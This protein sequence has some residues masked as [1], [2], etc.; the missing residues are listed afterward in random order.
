M[1][2]ANATKTPDRVSALHA[3]RDR[4]TGTGAASQRNRLLEAIQLLGHVTT[5]EASRGLDIYDPRARKM[6]LAKAGYEITTT[7]RITVTESGDR[8]RIGVYTLNR[9]GN[10]LAGV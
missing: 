10:K 8:H 1:I 3:I 2:T 4:Y 5:F 9:S 7:W 6:E